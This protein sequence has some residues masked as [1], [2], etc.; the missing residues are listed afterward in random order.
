MTED[1]KKPSKRRTFKGPLKLAVTIIAIA[2]SLFHLYTAAFRALNPI[3]QRS[4]HL[5]FVL[6]LIYLLYPATSKSPKHR[7][8]IFDYGFIVI[9]IV[10]IANISVRFNALVKSG[11][12]YKPLDIVFG[13]LTVLVV[14]EAA[15]RT[16]GYALP[17]MTG[18]FFLYG[19][20]G[21]FVPG[22]LMH[23]GYSYRRIIQHL[24]LTTEGIFGQIL[25][26]S[27]TYIYMFIL[28]GAFLSATGMSEFFNDLALSLAGHMKGGP[29][30]VSV[31]SSGLMGS[32]SGSTSANVVTTGSF[33]IPLMMKTGYSD[34]F[35][36]GIEAAASAGGQIMPPVMGAAAFII[37]DALG[38]PFVQLLKSALIPAVLYY[39]GVWTM[40]HFR[41]SKDGIK[42]LNKSELPKVKDVL[43][44]RGY[45]AI[46]LVG[47]IYMLVVGYNALYAA[48]WGIILAVIASSFKK[49]TRIDL[50]ALLQA[51]EAG[52]LSAVP[53][54]M[55]CG[56]IGIVVGITSLTG[57]ILSL[58][59]AI[60]QLSGGYLITTLI[61][62]MLV[63]LIMGMGL[64]TTACYVL[65]SAVAAPALVRLGVLPIAAH[66]F[67]F[68]FGILSTITP[69]VAVGSYAAA[70]ISGADPTKTGW[71]GVKLAITGFI[72]PFMFVYSPDLL[73]LPGTPLIKVIPV[74][75]TA[76]IGVIA[77]GSAA[78]GY[79]MDHLGWLA[80]GIILIG[81]LLL[82][83]SGLYTDIIGLGLLAAVFGAQYVQIKRK[84]SPQEAFRT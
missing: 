8:S 20:Y 42:G 40:V 31:L 38:M 57:A 35:A 60:I 23:S 63:S 79:F 2:M 4:I 55:A 6:V 50:K 36:G 14:V 45:L 76:I 24:Y 17:I 84:S 33:T 25:G 10:S 30:K 32:I 81:A 28:F 64:P 49:A 26:V 56:I 47:M 43:L 16:V 41:A 29:A 5:I 44:S 46:P 69:P 72:V 78:E 62:T 27:S 68:Y 71:A 15:R 74:A 19:L 11:G 73:I 39:V 37:A 22:P 18:V 66:L 3:Q 67:V 75:A 59:S 52:A 65:T 58:A 80:R 82:I 54:A 12:L 53:V 1:T 48:V 83:N 7:P 61:L 70:G 34:F 13:I 77:L 51:L 9:S 21:R